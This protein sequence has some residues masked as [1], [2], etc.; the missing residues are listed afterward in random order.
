MLREAV[1]KRVLWPAAQRGLRGRFDRTAARGILDDAFAAY[2]ERRRGLP[3][4]S[5]AGGRFMVH[6][7]ALT[8]A[9][10]RTLLSHGLSEADACTLTARVTWQAYE[11]M[12]LFPTAISKI[13][14][15]PGRKRLERATGAFRKFPFGPPSY[16]MED[17]ATADDSVAF[18]VRRC[19]VAEYF[20]SEGLARLCVES[21]CNLD[22]G[23]ARMWDATLE[24]PHT[25]AAGDDHCNFRWRPVAPERCRADL[26]G[27]GDRAH[28]DGGGRE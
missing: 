15:K 25:L 18:D 17:V 27:R 22:F 24:R 19:P 2:E 7:A 13:G 21:W 1:L 11:K 16:E 3:E 20:A 10:Y 28:R 8:V 9:L 5:S 12:A 4:E 14:T 26:E 23:L 6:L